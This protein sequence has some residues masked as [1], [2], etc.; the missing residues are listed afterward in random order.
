MTTTRHRYRA[1]KA[2]I[3]ILASM[4]GLSLL[5]GMASA[6]FER[7]KFTYRNSNC[8]SKH[9]DPLNVWWYRNSNAQ[10][11]AILEVDLMGWHSQKGG[12]QYF[13]SHGFC[14]EMAGQ[15]NLGNKD[16]HHT[17]FFV[18]PGTTGRGNEVVFGDAHRERKIECQGDRKDAVY[19]RIHGRTGFDQGAKEIVQGMKA[20]GHT[21]GGYRKSGH[22]ERF[23]QCNGRY[24]GWNGRTQVIGL[25]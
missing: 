13:S 15:R 3:A 23:K 24:V 1:A 21:Y 19:G 9:I 2:V 8:T 17:R 22:R 5:T 10:A 12:T 18:M 14:R 20:R 7:S 16:K 11:H 6:H 4:M 25:K